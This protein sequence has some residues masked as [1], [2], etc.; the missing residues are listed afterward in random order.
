LNAAV[1]LPTFALTR[2]RKNHQLDYD[3]EPKDW[4]HP[5]DS[6]RINEWTE[7]KEH[8]IQIYTDGSKNEQGVGSGIAIYIQ[9]KLTHQIKHKLH[10]RCSNN[11]AEQIAIVKVLQAIE[12]IK[13]NNNIPITITIY[14]D[15]RIT[16]ESL[17]NTK[18]RKHL[19]EEISKKTIALERENWIIEY[20][21]IKAHAGHYGNEPADKLAQEATRNNDICYN[22]IAKS[23]IE[24]R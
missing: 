1:Q 21:W 2:D 20:T 14:T 7:E 5:A 11:Q 17:K 10:D 4:I 15:G 12:T 8:T 3:A 23:E 9:K 6:V 13:I 18:N 22:K 24:H 16:L 19:I